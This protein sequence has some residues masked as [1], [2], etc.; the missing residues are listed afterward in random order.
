MPRRK[1]QVKSQILEKNARKSLVHKVPDAD[2][3][4]EFGRRCCANASTI[5]SSTLKKQAKV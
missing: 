1:I 5:A 2:I 4:V 3:R